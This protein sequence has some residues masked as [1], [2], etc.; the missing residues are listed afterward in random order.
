V[1]QGQVVTGPERAHA[2]HVEVAGLEPGREYWYRFRAGGGDNAATSPVG[3]TRTAPAAGAPVAR[4]RFAFASCQHWEQGYYGAHRHM[5]D[6]DPDLVVFLGDY[7]YESGTWREMVRRHWSPEPTTLDGYRLRYA[8]Y[9]TDPDLQRMHAATPWLLTWDDHEVLN[10]YAG[11]LAPD[12]DPGFLQRRAAAYRAYFEHQPMRGLAGAGAPGAVG[13]GAASTRIYGS[14]AFGDLLSFHVLDTRQYR[15]PHACLVDGRGGGRL[16]SGCQEIDDPGRTMLGAAQERWLDGALRASAVRWNVLAQQ[17]LFS[18]WD[19][20]PGTGE[21]RWTD[22]WSGYPAA[23][24]RLTEALRAGGARNPVLIGGDVHKHI[25]ADVL[26]DFHRPDAPVVATEFCT[27]SITS[28]S[29][30]QWRIR[31]MLGDNP[32]V[33]LADAHWR[34]YALATVERERCSVQL[35][36]VDDERDPGTKVRTLARFAVEDGRPGAQSA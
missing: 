31:Q 18:A 29:W 20:E 34:G 22:G 33:R 11:E 9:K 15:S 30:P 14:W 5:L 28:R 16:V 1:R 36:V 8:Q 21:L 6:D 2:V 13:A 7:I 19:Y 32:H 10:D 23:R 27:T 4:L 12:R 3:R 35:R 26:A 25:V 24:T 17:T